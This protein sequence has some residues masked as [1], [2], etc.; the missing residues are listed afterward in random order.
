MKPQGFIRTLTKTKRQEIMASLLSPSSL[1]ERFPFL[2][3]ARPY[4]LTSEFN[5][6]KEFLWIQGH[7]LRSRKL[8]PDKSVL[9]YDSEQALAD[10]FVKS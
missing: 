10:N 7:Y 3:E 2:P 5:K 8:L 4:M 6:R 9:Q 1:S